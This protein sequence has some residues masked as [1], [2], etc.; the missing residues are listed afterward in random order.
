MPSRNGILAK[1]YFLHTCRMS[2]LKQPQEVIQ[3][4][5]FH[6]VL[7]TDY[8]SSSNLHI[9]LQP[10]AVKVCWLNGFIN[11]NPANENAGQET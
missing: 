9:K 2:V 11:Q 4:Q 8:Q 7:H 1:M 5:S 3:P 6:P 10:F